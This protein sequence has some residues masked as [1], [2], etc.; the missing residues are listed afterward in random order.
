MVEEFD[1]QIIIDRCRQLADIAQKLR[2]LRDGLV[3][4]GEEDKQS[5]RLAEVMGESLIKMNE[6]GSAILKEI[7]TVISEKQQQINAIDDMLN[8]LNKL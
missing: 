8:N 5:H 7:K 6:A 1:I 2:I 4:Q 3:L